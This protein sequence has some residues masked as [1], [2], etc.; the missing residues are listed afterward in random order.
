MTEKVAAVRIRQI[1]D[2][3]IKTE[4][5]FVLYWMI[6][7]RRLTS[8]LSLQRAV[9][10]AVAVN[11]PL[12]IFEPLR[13]DYQWASV[14]LHRF[15]IQGMADNAAKALEAQVSYFPYVEP[16][17]GAGSGLLEALAGKSCAVVT[18]DFPCFFLPQMVEAVGRRLSVAME[19]IDSNGLYPMRATER[20]FTRA[21][22]FRNHLQK[23]LAPYLDQFPKTHP[24]AHRK[25]VKQNCIPSDILNRW[26]QASDNLLAASPATLS[27]LPV[28]SSVTA[29]AF[30]GGPN[31]AFTRLKR[32]LQIDFIR[33]ADD[34]NQP[35]NDPSSGLSP[36]LHFGHISAHEIFSEVAS[37]E[38][39]T[40]DSLGDVKETKGSRNGWWGMSPHAEAFLDELVT[41]REIGYNAGCHDSNYA[42]F[43][44][45][46]DFAKT[47]LEL[48]AGDPRSYLY[49]YEDFRDAK[50]HDDIW[51]A[52]QNQLVTEGRMHNYLRMLWGK[53]I[54]EWSPSAKDA[55]EIMIDLNNRYA[56]DGRNPNS[57]SG[58]L[59]VLGKYDR[60]WGPER[61]IFGK[62]RY[63]SSDSTRRKLRLT[64]YLKKYCP[65]GQQSLFN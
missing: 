46:P 1:N 57:Y 40:T 15:V 20:I 60:A 58:I 50:T 32:F 4:G 11:K 24:L 9:E 54:L 22:S 63:M 10:L 33:Y 38:S 5:E 34:R 35:D 26:P 42:S 53:K 14:R 55:L 7:N 39:W 2:R 61:P 44:S 29:A 18:D 12:L 45:I 37:H 41:W 31:A 30:E 56:V 65:D 52:A 36:Y 19:A 16:H 28:D 43:E 8:N 6:A 49:T 23:T 64:E 27:S 62:V 51:N 13:C 21:F 17:V 47:T 59:W 48:H 3:P 25:L